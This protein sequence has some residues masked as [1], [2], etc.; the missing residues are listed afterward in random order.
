MV[1]L[2]THRAILVEPDWDELGT[3]WFQTPLSNTA[4]SVVGPVLVN[5]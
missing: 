4:T 2:E 1:H 3:P 5:H